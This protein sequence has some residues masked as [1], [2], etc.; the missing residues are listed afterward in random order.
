TWSKEQSGGLLAESGLKPAFRCQRCC[1]SVSSCKLPQE[2]QV[3]LR[4]KANVRYIEQNHCE[5]VHSQAEG[6]ASPL[7]RIVSAVAARCV[8]GF[9][10]SRMDHPASTNFNPLFAPFHRFRFYV[11][12]ETRFRERKIM[13]P[14]THGGICSQKLAQE[15][16]K[17][18]LQI[19]NADLFIHV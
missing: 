8:Y 13:R 4:E 9:E 2:T 12:F 7:L 18:P 3:V 14:K 6:E 1:A 10:D 15:K 11:D 17:R 19:G 16:F 5:P